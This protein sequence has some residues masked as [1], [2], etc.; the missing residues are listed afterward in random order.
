MI[1]NAITEM[2]VMNCILDVICGYVFFVFGIYKQ[3][4]LLRYNM[5]CFIVLN[6]KKR[7][8]RAVGNKE[9]FV[10]KGPHPTLLQVLST[11]LTHHP[12]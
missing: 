5:F 8:E 9:L 4:Y 7:K 2:S 12:P 3:R 11:P 6:G 10:E 1:A